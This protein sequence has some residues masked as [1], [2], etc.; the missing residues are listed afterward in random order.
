M[1]K[2]IMMEF[3]TL[4]ELIDEQNEHMDDLGNCDVVACRA[5]AFHINY[6]KAIKRA[7]DREAAR[8]LNLYPNLEETLLNAVLHELRDDFSYLRIKWMKH[9]TQKNPFFKRLLKHIGLAVLILCCA[10][11]ACGADTFD[12]AMDGIHWAESRRG[13]T[14]L[15]L[16]PH[17]DGSSWGE[18]GVTY[19]AVRELQRAG[20][21]KSGSM[22]FDHKTTIIFPGNDGVYTVTLYTNVFVFSIGDNTVVVTG[23]KLD[24]SNPVVNKIVAQ[25]YLRWMYKLN[26]CSSWLAA[27]GWYHGGGQANRNSYIENI[28]NNRN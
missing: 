9:L 3:D 28:T 12:D 23:N 11:V 4:I 21:L 25:F 18:Y 20:I 8:L 13:T 5:A 17:A 15:A 24:L 14:T 27:A 10:G 6:M 19:G 1:K 7:N 26:K 2:P 16:Y 22:A